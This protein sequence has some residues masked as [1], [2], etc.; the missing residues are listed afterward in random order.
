MIEGT[1]YNIMI[2]SPSDVKHIADIAVNCIHRWNTL[3][4]NARKIALVPH[5]WTSSSYPSLSNTPQGVINTQMVDRSDALVA[6]FGSRLGT[7]TKDYISGTVEEINEHRKA[8]KPVM[9]FFSES[10]DSD[11]DI[12][13]LKR[14]QE[15]RKSLGNEGL[16]EMYSDAADFQKKFAEKLMLFSQKEFS[17][18]DDTRPEQSTAQTQTVTFSENEI[19]IIKD[20]TKSNAGYLSET[21]FIGG[22]AGFSFGGKQYMANSPKEVA[23]MEDFIKRMLLAKYIELDGFNKQGKPQYKLT[24]LAYETFEDINFCDMRHGS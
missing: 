16:Y 8:G 9:V 11:V 7:P 1:I 23:M 18:S 15:F 6:I 12:E 20:W 2:G 19:A 5:H 14:L 13:E 21:H 22:K 17:S 3:N 24:L 10:Y 4:T